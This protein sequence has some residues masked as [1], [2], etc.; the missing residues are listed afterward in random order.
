V[1]LSAA[2]GVA[3]SYA[4]GD[5][6]CGPSFDY[7]DVTPRGGI[8]GEVGDTIN[9]T[10]LED[11]QSVCVLGSVSLYNPY[12]VMGAVT[13]SSSDTSVMTVSG[14]SV[15]LVG[16]G[17]ATLSYSYT[18]YTDVPPPSSEPCEDGFCPNVDCVP[19]DVL[20]VEH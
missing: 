16:E 14:A 6:C 7:L 20:R 12:N 17:E 9:F 13:F 3:S 10:A 2:A 5:Y 18:G 8:E 1:S 4:C 19:G 11:D 15:Q